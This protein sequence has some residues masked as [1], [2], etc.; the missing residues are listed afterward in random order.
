L[1]ILEV[2][3][4]E[5]EGRFQSLQKWVS[6]CESILRVKRGGDAVCVIFFWDFYPLELD[7][8]CPKLI[9]FEPDSISSK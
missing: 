9:I 7:W 1:E 8:Q 2:F 3:E 5:L 6:N 4:K